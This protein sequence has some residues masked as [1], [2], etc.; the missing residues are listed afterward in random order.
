MTAVVMF[1]SI[2]HV[3]HVAESLRNHGSP[4]ASLN[5]IFRATVMAMIL[6][7]A[8]AWSGFCSAADRAKLDAFLQE[9]WLLGTER[10]YYV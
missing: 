6:Y 1:Q 5:D 3:A 10:A 7:C 8:P 9:N 2:V 4:E